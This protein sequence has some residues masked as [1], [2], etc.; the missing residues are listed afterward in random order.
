MPNFI[1][2]IG[3]NPHP[4]RAKMLQVCRCY[5]KPSFLSPLFFISPSFYP[6]IKLVS[7][8]PLHRKHNFT[9]LQT[10]KAFASST[11]EAVNNGSSGNNSDTFFAN[12]AVSW[13]SLG[14]SENLIHSLSNAGF[15]RPSIIQ[16][17]LI[18]SILIYLSNLILWV[19]LILHIFIW[20]SWIF[21]YYPDPDVGIE[22]L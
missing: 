10:A 3:L 9:T 15:P 16:V 18:F 8:R 17:S 21:D 4:P 1:H 20:V 13:T 22:H 14:L 11:A 19:I 7:L 2:W 5:R 6:P 12:D